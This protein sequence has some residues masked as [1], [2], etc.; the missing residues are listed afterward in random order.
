VS[1]EINGEPAKPGGNFRWP[2]LRGSSAY[3]KLKG[4]SD[5][6]RY[7]TEIAYASWFTR[8]EE[9]HFSEAL[10]CAAR[11]LLRDAQTPGSPPSH[12]IQAVLHY[13][14]ISRSVADTFQLVVSW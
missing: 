4:R 13:G 5:R 3:I 12:A 11:Q 10:G 7:G 2:D 9:G 1:A 8:Q 14:L 6:W